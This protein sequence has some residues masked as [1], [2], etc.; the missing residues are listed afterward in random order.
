MLVHG[1]G[2]ADNV[3]LLSG[4]MREHI[5]NVGVT[6]RL[7]AVSTDA[8]DLTGGIAGVEQAIFGKK[9]LLLK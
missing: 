7:I 9:T 4:D 2:A 3:C 6:L 8:C 1:E 5:T